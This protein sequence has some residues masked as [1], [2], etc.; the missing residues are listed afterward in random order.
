MCVTMNILEDIPV[1]SEIIGRNVYPNIN[2][3][4]SLCLTYTYNGIGKELSK[5]CQ[6]PNVYLSVVNQIYF[7]NLLSI[8]C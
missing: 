2:A 6:T 3:L 5:F 4:L 1:P 8:I 7:L